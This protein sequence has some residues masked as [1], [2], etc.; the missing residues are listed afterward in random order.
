MRIVGGT[1]A[2]REARQGG[3]DVGSGV[4]PRVCIA[5]GDFF[6][7]RISYLLLYFAVGSGRF[8]FRTNQS[9]NTQFLSPLFRWLR[10]SFISA[11]FG[12]LSCELA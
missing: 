4:F 7:G 6:G 3:R 1:E 12:R 8:L 2:S 5:C 10:T 11:S 9:W